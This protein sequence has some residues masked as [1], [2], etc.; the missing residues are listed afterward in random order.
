MDE[1]TKKDVRARL[2]RAVGQVE[3]VLRMLE[4]ERYCVDLLMQIAAARAA[5]GKA[6][7]VLLRSHVDTCVTDAFASHDP[8]EREAKAAELAKVFERYMAS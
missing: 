6:G 4:D 5:L 2:K 7:G 8:A 3:G 1:A